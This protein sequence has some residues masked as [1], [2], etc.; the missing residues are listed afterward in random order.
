M[1]NPIKIYM[2]DLVHDILPG[3]YVVP[4]N[5]SNIAVYVKKFFGKDIKIE[6]FKSPSGLLTSIKKDSPHILALSNY[7]WNQH[8]SAQIAKQVK[9]DFTD[10]VIVMGGPGVRTDKPGI[11]KFLKQN[12][13]VDIYTLFE[14]EQPFVNFIKKILSRS[15]HRNK[16]L[17]K[18]FA[19]GEIIKGC[20]YLMGDIMV[21]S[22]CDILSNLDIFP[23]P[24][25]TG[26]LDGFLKK[27]YI[28][29]FESNRGCPFSC[30]FCNWGV[31]AL[32]KVRIFPLER[33]C[34]E[35]EYVARKNPEIPYW[36]IADANFGI[37]KRDI[38]IAQ[39]I[40]TIKKRT[41]ALRRIDIWASKN[42]LEHN[43]KISEMLGSKDKQL[44]AVQTFDPKVQ[45]AIGR[46]NIIQ[47]KVS[48]LVRELRLKG[49]LVSTDI[50]C[51][52]SLETAKSHI[53]TL[54]KC[55]D[56]DF[57]AIDVGNTILLPGT[58]LES[59]SSRE[60]FSLRTK[61]RLRQGSYGIYHG[62][63]AIE[64]EEIIVATS[65]MTEEEMLEFRL[66]HW[67]IWFCWNTGFLR[68]ALRYLKI[69]HKINT[70]EL[71]MNIIKYDKNNYPRVER[72]FE[73]FCLEAKKEK[74]DSPEELRKHYSQKGEFE[75]LLRGSFSKLNFKF[76]ALFILDK[77]LY[78]EFC[79]LIHEVAGSLAVG[80]IPDI[81]CVLIKELIVDVNKLFY[82]GNILEKTIKIKQE[83]AEFF[84][85]GKLD[86]SEI[87][88]YINLYKNQQDVVF[89]KELLRKYEFN[90]F[91]RLAIEKSLEVVYSEFA[92]QIKKSNS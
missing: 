66:I 4:L 44:I 27:E 25:L 71:I 39:K 74:F 84:L 60:R 58:E 63:T 5:I 30:S 31:S 12:S 43:K 24:Y 48:S 53:Q 45:R 33:I 56:I 55:F 68:S 35:M 80:K 16:G 87:Y 57:D 21:Y 22:Q 65:T 72:L 82:D 14:G 70:M 92:Y 38:Q 90:K 10:I 36:I 49:L 77:Q 79:D 61:F 18:C 41:P 28:P 40:K 32:R 13:Y 75:E 76:A 62:I 78:I 15:I 86:N 47:G 67:L 73:Q 46:A 89:L 83:I 3:N 81:L 52:L 50:L 8:L 59:D 2:A 17:K 7:M 9:K 88:V 29:L 64:C 51:G 34:S 26:W 42:R 91:K 1:K 54:R 11:K 85:N 19:D 37:L 23:S 6:L 20:T 69:Y